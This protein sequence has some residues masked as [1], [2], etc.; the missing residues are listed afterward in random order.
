VAGDLD[1]AVLDR[2]D[3]AL[4]FGLPHTEERKKILDLYLDR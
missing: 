1:D 4:E 3:E 2:M